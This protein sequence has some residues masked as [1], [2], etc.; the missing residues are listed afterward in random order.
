MDTGCRDYVPMMDMDALEPAHLLA[1]IIK[2]APKLGKEQ[3]IVMHLCGGARI[4]SR[5]GRFWGWAVS[6]C[7]S[8]FDQFSKNPVDAMN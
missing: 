6:C 5:S 1:E 4:F 3:I 7:T 8:K 2:R